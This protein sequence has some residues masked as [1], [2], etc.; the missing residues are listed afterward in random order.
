MEAVPDTPEPT[1]QAPGRREPVRPG[2]TR[3]IAPAACCALACLLAWGA[4][5]AAFAEMT[6][7][8]ATS[9]APASVRVES[10]GVDCPSAEQVESALAHVGVPPAIATKGWVLSYGTVPSS[11]ATPQT[12]FVWMDLASPTGQLFARRKLL[13]DGSDCSAIASAIS[14]VAE[15]S[16]HELG[17]TRGEPLPERARPTNPEGPSGRATKPPRLILGLGPAAG[18]SATVGLNLLLEARLS[19]AGPIS[20]RL[21]GGLLA[22]EDSQA[23]GNGRARMSSR[24]VSAAVLSTL[25]VGKLHLDAG[26]VLL[27]TLDQGRT[28]NLPEMAE[29][30]RAALAAGLV[31]GAGVTLS[32]RW[33]L[34]LDVQGLRTVAGADFVVDIEGSR[35]A[36][37]APPAWQGIVCAK[38]EFVAWP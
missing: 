25:P 4:S 7:G 3:P 29:G 19:I 22:H 10:N 13:D 8:P 16:L 28:E 9:S 30:R 11:T 38:L 1:P 14:A 20:F 18:T 17:W 34:A 36:V 27:A 23:V 5:P 32:P 37:L 31:L 21:G 26:A 33:R 12:L 6:G 2:R 24:H 35:R 15:R